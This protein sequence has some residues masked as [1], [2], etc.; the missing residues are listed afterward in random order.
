MVKN[1][2]EALLIELKGDLNKLLHQQMKL[3]SELSDLEIQIDKKKASIV[4]MEKFKRML[5]ISDEEKVI[6]KNLSIN[7]KYIGRDESDIDQLFL[8]E[9]KP[10]LEPNNKF[11][12]VND[13]H[14]LSFDIY[15]HLFTF[16]APGECYR[17]ID[18]IN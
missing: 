16:I 5:S 6:L 12:Y 4:E 9:Q 1:D 10:E 17:I 11:Y 7:W 3:N 14:W 18:I 2:A 15:N 8:Y 13:G